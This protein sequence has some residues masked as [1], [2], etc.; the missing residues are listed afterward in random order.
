MIMKQSIKLTIVAST[1][2]ILFGFTFSSK[3]SALDVTAKSCSQA[4]VQA[5]AKQV[6]AAGGG[7]VY[8]PKGDCTWP[9]GSYGVSTSG[10]VSFMGAGVGSTIIRKL[11]N[12]IF[13]ITS[14]GNWS[15]ISGISFENS[16]TTTSG[17]AI[18]LGDAKNFRIDHNEF[19]ESRWHGVIE[20]KRAVRGLIDHNTFRRSTDGTSDYGIAWQSNYLNKP[21]VCT[22]SDAACQA[23]WD[24]WWDDPKSNNGEIWDENFQ[25]GSDKAIFV[26][27]NTFYWKGSTIEGNWGSAQAMV[28]RYNYVENLDGNNGG[29]KP[30]ARWCEIYNN[31]FKNTRGDIGDAALYIRSSSLVYNNTFINYTKGGQFAAWYCGT[32]YCYTPQVLMKDTFIYNNT[33]ENCKYPFDNGTYWD[34]W[35]EGSPERISENKNYFF[36]TPQPGDRIYPYTPFTYP[37][38][39]ASSSSKPVSYTSPPDPPPNAPKNLRIINP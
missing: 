11:G 2:I 6:S 26:E 3:T 38:P 18:Y 21:V 17:Q 37:H 32:D 20:M 33:Y 34:K 9:S 28:F 16:S 31:T 1:L 22:Y 27:D 23:K 39:L 14:V 24:A 5:A 7:T 30:G 12:Y 19:K 4:D 10:S 35:T 29:I 8:I 13:Y 25:Y 15:R 36:R